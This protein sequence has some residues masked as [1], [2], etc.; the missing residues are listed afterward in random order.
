MNKKLTRSTRD[1]VIS[2]VCGGFGEYFSI[3]PVIVRIIWVLIT[4]MNFMTGMLAYI[5]CVIVI[6]EDNEV[7]Y[8][9]GSST[10]NTPI[11]IGL[12]LI[13]VG[14]IKLI[15]ILFP[16]FFHMFNVF[17][18]FKYWPVLLILTGVYI[19]AKQKKM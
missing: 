17:K 6:P 11:F 7:I 13:I 16:R 5:V 1:T 19:I 14:G 10:R 12:I 2:G 3:D 8:D 9:S 4:T 15:D 18:L